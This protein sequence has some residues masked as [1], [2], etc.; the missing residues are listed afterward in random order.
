[1]GRKND[2]THRQSDKRLL[3]LT[4]YCEPELFPSSY[5]IGHCNEALARAGV[6]IVAYTPMPTRGVTREQRQEYRHRRAET[7]LGGMMTLHRYPMF[8]EGSNV[9][10]RALRYTLICFMEFFIGTF[11]RDARRCNAMLVFSTPPI[12]GA[13]AAMVK[14]VRRIPFV[15]G[16]QDIFPDSLVSTGI[17]RRG[18]MAWKTGRMI[19]NFTYRNADRIIVISEDFR[20]NIMAKGVPAE[21]IEV[22]P[23]WVD[24]NVLCDIPRDR[25]VLIGRYGLDPAKFYVTYCGNI[26]LTQNLGMLLDVARSLEGDDSLHFVLIG[27]GAYR[28]QLEQMVEAQGVKNVTLL[29]FQPYEDIAHVFALGDASLVISKP[30]TGAS[31]VPSKTWSIMAASR[32]VLASFDDGELRSIIEQ[33]HCGIFTPA[34]DKE[35]FREAILSL[36]ADRDRCQQ[37]GDNGRQYVRQYLTKEVGTQRYVQIVKHVKLKTN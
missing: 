36:H 11:A 28:Q 29:P 37:M 23:N 31:S 26:G 21:K 15:Y 3:M 25:N 6:E 13:M 9:L 30:G 19:E 32:P 33:H 16:L 7:L 27:N 35:A 10:I 17:A 18:G 12:Q 24:D 2:D 34:G 4:T 14:K 1:M 8:G 22:I 20:K 5:L